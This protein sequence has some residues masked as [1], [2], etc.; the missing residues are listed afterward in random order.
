MPERKV[1][2]SLP[3]TL[4]GAGETSPGMVN[5]ALRIAP[6]LVAADGGANM[7]VATGFLPEAVIGDLDSL[8]PATIAA[9]PAG[10]L[11]RIAEQETTDFEKC[12]SRIE[13]PFILGL[14]FSGPR[15]DHAL[16]VWSALLRYPDRR[17]V[18]IGQ[19]DLAFL[20][21]KGQILT[22]DLAPDTR[23][24]L[25]PLGPVR[26]ESTGL[27]WPIADLD[28]RPEGR[29]GTSNAATGPVTLIFDAARMIV[30]LPKDCLGAAIAALAP[31][32]RA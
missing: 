30:I 19:T 17:C 12:L 31:A 15:L 21:P 11:W 14:G 22:V 28:F 29:I 8:D 23:V 20:A 10:R 27:R 5:D 6:C 4:L 1:Q 24:S 25:F 13:A 7:A 9:I 26:G 18:I 3:V 16:A 2:S 32:D